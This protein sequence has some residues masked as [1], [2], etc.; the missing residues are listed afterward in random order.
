[1]SV[2]V[3]IVDSGINGAH[4]HVGAARGGVWIQGEGENED[5]TDYIGHGTAVAGAI[6]E[7]AP[8]AELYAVRIFERRL[9]A[10]IRVLMRGLDWCLEHGM[11]VINLSVGTANDEHQALLEDFVSRARSEHVFI[12]SAVRLLPGRLDGVIGVDSDAACPR[13]TCRFDQGVFFASPYPRPIPGV[14]LERNLIGVSFAIAN[15]SGLL[16]RFLESNSERRA[17]PEFCGAVSQ[18]RPFRL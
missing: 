2:R 4:P 14:P 13:D 15:C 12:V 7:K 16:A 9:S 10:S 8:H 3:G 11:N 17:W 1:M 5:Y 6:R 18:T